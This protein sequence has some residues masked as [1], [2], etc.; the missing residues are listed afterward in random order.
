MCCKI[1]TASVKTEAVVLSKGVEPLTFSSVVRC[2]IQ[3]SYESICLTNRPQIYKFYLLI[4][5]LCHFV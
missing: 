3:L 1:A 4:K 5:A 2:S